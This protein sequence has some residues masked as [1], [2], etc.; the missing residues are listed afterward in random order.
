[1]LKAGDSFLLPK[2]G[3]YQIEHLWVI[4]Y[5]ADEDGN[6]ICVNITKQRD[7]CDLTTQ[8]QP[9]DHPF[10]KYP[11]VV[12]YEDARPMNIAKVSAL[13]SSNSEAFVCQRHE[14][15]RQEILEK[16]R[17]GAIKSKRTRNEI[18]AYCRAAQSS[19]HL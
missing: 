10:V 18:K 15:F 3:K 16:I 12:F 13:A 17:L 6:A 8:L 19:T 9:G 2:P 1:M 11:S 4:L 14:P 7:G 5:D